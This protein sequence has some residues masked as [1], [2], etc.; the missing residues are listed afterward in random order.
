MWKDFVKINIFFLIRNRDQLIL[1]SECAS[2]E[3]AKN[4]IDELFL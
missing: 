4:L 1:E 2:P 3:L